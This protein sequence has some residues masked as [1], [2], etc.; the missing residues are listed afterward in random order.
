[1]AD[2]HNLGERRGDQARRRLLAMAPVT[3][4]RLTLAGVSTAFL[5]GGSGPPVV[6]LHGPGS[7]GPAWL[8]VIP[9]LLGSHRVI[10]PDLPG[11]GASVVNDGR[12]DADRFLDWLGELVEQT[13]RTPAVLVGHLTG[14]ALAARYAS[15]HPQLVSRLIL[16]VPMGIAPFEPTPDFG[17]A[18]TSFASEPTERSHDALWRACVLDLDGL[19]ERMGEG[20]ATMRRYNLDLVTTPAVADAQRVLLEEFGFT[21]VPTEIL[22]RISVPTRLIWGRHDAIVRLAIGEAAS[23]RYGWPLHVVEGAGNEPALEAPEAFVEA[24]FETVR[25]R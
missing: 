9:A 22:A 6:L 19:R 2:E 3:E 8:P 1:M 14:G 18:L 7:Y 12:L 23:A 5:E 11:Q 25:S 21:V 16:V 20:W 17:A 13:C 10:A 24:A 15:H 4:R